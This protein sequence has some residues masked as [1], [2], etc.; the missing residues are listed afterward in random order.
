MRLMKTDFVR[1]DKAFGNSGSNRQC[2]KGSGRT[3]ISEPYNLVHLLIFLPQTFLPELLLQKPV[4]SFVILVT[5][6]VVP[7][8]VT[9]VSGYCS[10][11]LLSGCHILVFIFVTFH[12][13]R[14]IEC[15]KE[16]IL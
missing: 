6:W 4:V 10:E 11:H 15:I 14:V 13:N 8:M 12:P 9:N 7:S 3:R 5:G 16:M 2:H 1:P